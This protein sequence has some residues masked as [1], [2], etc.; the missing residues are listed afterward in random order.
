[1]STLIWVTLSLFFSLRPV[2]QVAVA[3]SR[4]GSPLNLLMAKTKLEHRQFATAAARS[5]SGE[6]PAPS[7]SGG[8][9]SPVQPR[10]ARPEIDQKPILILAGD[11]DATLLAHQTSFLIP[12]ADRC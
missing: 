1:M 8:G 12:S 3:V 5:C 2:S 10:N 9:S 11:G 6:G 4:P 7:P